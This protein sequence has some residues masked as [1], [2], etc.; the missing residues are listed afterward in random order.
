MPWTNLADSG[1]PEVLR[2]GTEALC[3]ADGHPHPLLAGLGK[4]QKGGQLE[5]LGEVFQGQ[6]LYIN[7]NA[8]PAGTALLSLSALGMRYYLA[9][10][11]RYRLG[12]RNC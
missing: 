12:S 9:V 10:K 11:V 1:V 7:R 6:N 2:L 5:V 3:S 4:R 8:V